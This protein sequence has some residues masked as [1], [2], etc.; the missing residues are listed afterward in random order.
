[1]SIDPDIA[2]DLM[3][4]FE[5]HYDELQ[6]ALNKLIHYPEDAEQINLIFR[7]MHTIKGNA[8][9]MQLQELVHFAHSME[10][11]IDAMRNGNFSPTEQLCDLILTGTDR[12]RDLHKFYLY[13]KPYEGFDEEQVAN[14]FWEVSKATCGQQ[15]QE[16]TQKLYRVLYPDAAESEVAIDDNFSINHVADHANYLDC[17]EGTLS[18]LQLFRELALQ[19]DE[20]ND[21]WHDRTDLLV[22]MGIKLC[23]LSTEVSIN[24]IQLVA[25][26]Y[27][28]DIGMTFLPHE[29]V[30]KQSK[31]NAME[32]KKLK[33][34]VEWG[35]G[36]LHRMT[37]WEEAATMV[38]QHHEQEDGS[39]YPEGLNSELLCDGAKIISILDAFYA[40]T[41]LRSDR[42]HRRSVLRAVS[43][44]NACSG[45]QFS[46]YWVELFNQLIRN[47]V[48]NGTV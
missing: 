14:C 27:M 33:K 11:T 40:M 20:Q 34:H 48:K 15:A 25:A 10:D 47:E 31:L 42:S 22:F 44:I 16:Y 43:E 36:I 3:S 23:Q 37:G 18:D 41:N 17:D 29:L 4:S 1:M 26:L 30:N 2:E 45:S 21:F 5:E 8:S 6:Y 46:R 24:K 7:S 9:M 28:H 35:H 32:F 13:D 39:G 12:L 19:T 38:M